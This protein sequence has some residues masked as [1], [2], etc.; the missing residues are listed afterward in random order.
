[1]TFNSDQVSSAF[2]T[3]A[4]QIIGHFPHGL[5]AL[6]SMTTR[7]ADLADE[8]A[9]LGVPAYDLSLPS[10]HPVFRKPRTTSSDSPKTGITDPK[11]N[12]RLR[13]V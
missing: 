12:K 5:V 3:R 1:M 6:G 4:E 10:N 11:N 13:I 9:T 8:F 2:Q 7:S